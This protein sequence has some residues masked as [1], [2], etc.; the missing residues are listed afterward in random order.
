MTRPQ[1]WGHPV[2]RSVLRR[3]RIV[4]TVH[5]L[6]IFLFAFVGV[7]LLMAFLFGSDP[8]GKAVFNVINSEEMQ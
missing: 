5:T 2:P 7:G 8:I 1:T 3:R 6:L 4:G